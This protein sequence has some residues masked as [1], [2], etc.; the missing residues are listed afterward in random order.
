MKNVSEGK[1]S[2]HLL[3]PLCYIIY[4][5]FK[6]KFKTYIYYNIEYFLFFVYISKYQFYPLKYYYLLNF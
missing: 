3:L 1:G 2:V 4:W 5:K 6:G